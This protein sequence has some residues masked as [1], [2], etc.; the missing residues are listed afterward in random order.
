MHAR[1]C[2]PTASPRPQLDP[3]LEG[4]PRQDLPRLELARVVEV[5]GKRLKE[6]GLREH[7]REEVELEELGEWTER[8]RG[9]D[10]RGSL[11]GTRRDARADLRRGGCRSKREG[12]LRTADWGRPAT[13][14]KTPRLRQHARRREDESYKES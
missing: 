4:L 5:L 1:L 14:P 2:R 8:S 11:K 9:S 10:G 7:G 12:R 3:R 13:R 6:E